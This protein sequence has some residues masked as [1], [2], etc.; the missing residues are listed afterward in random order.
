MKKNLY[1]IK[2]ISR[3]EGRADF[4]YFQLVADFGYAQRVLTMDINII[5]EFCELPVRVLYDLKA[6][7]KLKVAEYQLKGE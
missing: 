5:S 1:V 2:K 3:K 4:V 7:E 6:D